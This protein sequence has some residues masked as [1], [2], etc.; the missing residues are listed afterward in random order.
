MDGVPT[1]KRGLIEKKPPDIDPRSTPQGLYRYVVS[2]HN[3][4]MN[5]WI[6]SNDSAQ[7][8]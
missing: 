1:R 2:T 7:V 4:Q 5:W 6:I 8:K 3:L